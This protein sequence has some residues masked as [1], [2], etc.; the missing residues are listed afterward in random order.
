MQRQCSPSVEGRAGGGRGGVTKLCDATA[1]AKGNVSDLSTLC[2]TEVYSCTTILV[3]YTCTW[4][5]VK[6]EVN[7]RR[8]F[9]LHSVQVVEETSGLV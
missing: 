9:F 6:G 7:A 8:V 1:S 4:M 2:V 3:S 5:R